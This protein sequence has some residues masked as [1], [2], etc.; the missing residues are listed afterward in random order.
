MA[1]PLPQTVI[2]QVGRPNQWQVETCDC[3]NDCTTDLCVKSVFCPCLI[4]GANESMLQTGMPAGWLLPNGSRPDD[5]NSE[6]MISAVLNAGNFVLGWVWLAV[7]CPAANPFTINCAPFHSHLKRL[8]I[9]ETY[10]IEGNQCQ[11]L[12]CH[13]CCTPCSLAQEYRELKGRLMR[14]DRGTIGTSPVAAM[15]QQHQ[16]LQQTVQQTMRPAA[17]GAVPAQ[18]PASPSPARTTMA[19]APAA[20]VMSPPKQGQAKKFCGKC[21]AQQKAGNK[22]CGGCGAS[23]S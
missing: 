19:T 4:L 15:A 8:Q 6:C 13:Y 10:G 9:R 20:N 7:C 18:V 12:L 22:F 21:G 3:N 11:D 5:N 1:A 23:V 2:L 16:I 14:G 17:P